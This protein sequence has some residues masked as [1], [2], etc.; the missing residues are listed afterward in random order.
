MLDEH[1]VA[2]AHT[3]YYALHHDPKRTTIFLHQNNRQ[4]PDGFLVRAQTGID[5]FRPVVV[6]RAANEQVAGDLFHI[7][8]LPKRPYYLVAPVQLRNIIQQ[9][10]AVSDTE[11]LCVYRLDPARFE[12]PL[13][14]LVVS[15]PAPDGSPRYEISAGNSVQASA[16]LNW[17]SPHFAE[18]YVYTEPAARRRGWGKA[19]VAALCSELLKKRCLPLYVVNEQNL[20]SINLATAVGFVDTGVREYTGQVV[21]PE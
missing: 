18:I 13:N 21:R 8:L 2:E 7:G 10:L 12:P 3:A 4:Q 11:L 17:Q 5:L 1:S 9:T 14:V 19:V 6:I 16:G 15:R 20:A